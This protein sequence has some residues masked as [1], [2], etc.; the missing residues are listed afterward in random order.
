[1]TFGF[2]DWRECSQTPIPLRLELGN[3]YYIQAQ[4][5][6]LK[7]YLGGTHSWL[8]MFSEHHKNWIVIEHTDLET[9]QY[10]NG[11]VLYSGAK[12]SNIQEHAPFVAIRKPNSQ[13]FGHNPVI[14]GF[15]VAPAYNKIVEAVQE[16]PIDEFRLLN[17]NCNTFTSYM[18]YKLNLSI[19]RPFKSVGFRNSNWWNKNYG[20]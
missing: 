13:W 20:T 17:R 5:W 18:L 10:Q 7:G 9:I 4:A 14:V 11:Q 8:A 2:K 16:Y 15:C 1:M 3:I 12:T 6:A 19:K